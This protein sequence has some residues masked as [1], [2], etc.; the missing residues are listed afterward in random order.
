MTR[1]HRVLKR[2]IEHFAKI[3]P[4]KVKDAA[5]ITERFNDAKRSLGGPRNVDTPVHALHYG[6]QCR[7]FGQVALPGE[8]DLW[9]AKLTCVFAA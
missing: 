2:G 9:G 3:R 5:Q 8:E 7:V 1:V 6:Y 4:A